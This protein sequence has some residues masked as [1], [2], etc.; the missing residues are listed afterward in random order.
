MLAAQHVAIHLI[1]V[2]L[3][4]LPRST[5][6]EVE[7]ENLSSMPNQTAN[8][9]RSIGSEG[10]ELS[11]S[12]SFNSEPSISES[13]VGHYAPLGGSII[14]SGATATAPHRDPSFEAQQNDERAEEHSISDP[15]SAEWARLRRDRRLE[16][17]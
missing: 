2:A 6:I 9:S 13:Q 14:S 16:I 12:L 10:D 3:F 11:G 5:G 17:P 4:A 7:Q 15:S 8:R 1:R